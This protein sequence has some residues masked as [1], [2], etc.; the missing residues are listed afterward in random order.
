M[1]RILVTGANK[2]IGLAIATA[3]LEQHGD[4]A[5]LLGSRDAGRGQAAVDGLVKAHADWAA[6]IA[7]LQIDVASDASVSAAAAKV[8]SEHGAT[9]LY[10]I[11]NNAG[12]GFGDGG[13]KTVLDVNILGVRR[14]CEAFLPLLDPDAGRIVNISSA[15]GPNYVNTCRAD[16]QRFFVDPN[17]T[18]SALQALMYECIA[19]SGDK[20]AFAAK[21]LGSGEPYG[22][23]KACLNSYTM[24]L[25]REHPKLRINACT[26]GFIETDLTRSYAEAQGKKPSDL[27]MKPPA[28]AWR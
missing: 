3:I 18:W 15:A 11:V 4:T 13:L 9:A 5:V 28:A 7:P 17:V 27:G 21:G 10:A 20:D 24:L 1:R 26:P 6:R 12:I 23:S 14:V 8:A 16:R 25:A 2:G 19:M 22:L